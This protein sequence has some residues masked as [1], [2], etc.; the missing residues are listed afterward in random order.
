MTLAQN[1]K[2]NLFFIAARER[3]KSEEQYTCLDGSTINRKYRCDKIPDCPDESDEQGCTPGK[4]KLLNNSP[5][6]YCY[7]S[8]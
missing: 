7:E 6:I 1:A 8:R 4:I 5:E 2:L 3:E